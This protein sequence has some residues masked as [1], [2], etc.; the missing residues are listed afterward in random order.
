MVKAGSLTISAG[1]GVFTGGLGGAE[2]IHRPPGFGQRL[3][4]KSGKLVGQTRPLK[5]DKFHKKNVKLLAMKLED[6]NSKAYVLKSPCFYV[7]RVL[8][9]LVKSW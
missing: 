7:N 4:E 2:S 3:P 5:N 8:I 1:I 6:Q 9:T